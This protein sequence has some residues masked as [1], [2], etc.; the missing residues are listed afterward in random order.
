MNKTKDIFMYGLAAL[1]SVFFFGVFIILARKVIPEG[2]KDLFTY[3]VVSL[4]NYEG[5]VVGYFFGAAVR[6]YNENNGNNEIKP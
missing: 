1:L 6:R 4:V 5:I 3:V 2:N